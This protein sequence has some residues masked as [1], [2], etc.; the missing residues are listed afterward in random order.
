MGKCKTAGHALVQ[1]QANLKCSKSQVNAFGKYKYRS[2][3]DILAALKAHVL[4][5]ECYV[6]FEDESIFCVGDRVYLKTTA[7]LKHPDSDTG[8]KAVAQAREPKEKKGMSEDQV[9]GATSSYARKYAL[10]ALFAIDDTKDSDFYNN[11]NST[12]K[13]QAYKPN[14]APATKPPSGNQDVES[15]KCKKDN[16]DGDAV[17]HKMPSGEHRY[18]CKKCGVQRV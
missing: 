3:E 7:V 11:E 12:E 14:R 18:F 6:V 13:K 15:R 16:C 2:C 10:N 8:V 4:A 5:T 17:A 1:I 9:T